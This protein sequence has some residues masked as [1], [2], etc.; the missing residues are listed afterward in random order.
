MNAETAPASFDAFRT[1]DLRGTHLSA[2]ELRSAMPRSTSASFDSVAARVEG[3]IADVRTRG[4][5]SLTELAQRFDGVEQHHPLVPAE[6]LRES[7]RTL[8]PSV[9]SALEES[10][11]RARAFAAAQKPEDVSLDIRPGAVLTHRWV[12]VGRVGLYVP[13]GLAVLASSVVMNVVPAQAAG[14][15]SIALASP[16]HKDFG[17][18]PHP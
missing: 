15:E 2:A 16:P 4:F 18:L 9:R 17:G 12:P 13:G 1:I 6:A 11:D 5:D 8:D 3:I 10:I 14:V 7:L